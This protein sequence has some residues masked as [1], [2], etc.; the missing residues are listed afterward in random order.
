MA[1]AQRRREGTGSK[2]GC[3]SVHGSL[4]GLC[5]KSET[6]AR[7][8]EPDA[9]PGAATRAQVER[10]GDGGGGEESSFCVPCVPR[11]KEKLEPCRRRE[12]GREGG[13]GEGLGRRAR[14][15]RTPC[16]IKLSSGRGGA[17][18]SPP[19]YDLELLPVAGADDR[20]ITVHGSWADR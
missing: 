20:R 4:Q 15:A 3:L 10:S 5:T 19:K 7:P 1:V 14:S 8:A 11:N 13:G 9:N 17:P 2:E 18:H 12:A 16:I 6:D